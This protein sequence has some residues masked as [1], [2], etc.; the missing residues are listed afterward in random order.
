MSFKYGWNLHNSMEQSRLKTRLCSYCLP[1]K[2]KVIPQFC[3]AH[4]F[5]AYFNNKSLRN[6][7]KMAAI[8]FTEL[9]YITGGSARGEKCRQKHG[10]FRPLLTV[11]A[12]GDV[13]KFFLGS[14]WLGA[15]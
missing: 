4:F 5:C 13:Q 1:A 7:F 15:L 6:I 10:G 11:I 14:L 12:K 9:Y 3:I 8:L 2:I